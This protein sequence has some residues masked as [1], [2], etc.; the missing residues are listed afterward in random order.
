MVNNTTQV[1]QGLIG[2]NQ[3]VIDKIIAHYPIGS[4]GISSVYDQ[5]SQI[6]TDLVFQCPA[7]RWALDTAST[8]IPAWRYYFN[9]SFANTRPFP[10]LGAY[11][12]S[13]IQLVFNTYSPA[14]VTTQEFALAETIRG[15]WA[16]FARN[17]DR[18]PGWNRVGTGA[19]GTVLVGA[20]SNATGGILTDMNRI[21]QNGSF[22]L[23]LLGNRGEALSSGVTVIDESEV[24]SRC[25][26]YDSIYDANNA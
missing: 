12:S 24:D 2:N 13:E 25:S 26:I 15:T 8:G 11:H 6:Y 23:G 4:P 21:S 20:D 22:Y 5:S 10:N 17:P 7:R 14:Q 19:S 3:E 18:G 9:A 16:R 1:L